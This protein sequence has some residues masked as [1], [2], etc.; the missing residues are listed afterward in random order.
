MKQINTVAMIGRGAIGV[1]YG[2]LFKDKLDDNM[3]YIVDK[4][5]KEK[6]IKNG[7]IVNGKAV[8]FP[9][10]TT[11]DEFQPVDLVFISTK[12]AGLQDAIELM[13]DFVKEDTI[14]VSCLNGIR[15]EDILREAYPNNPVVRTIV[16]GMD[17]TYLHDEVVFTVLGELLFGQELEEEKEAVSL[18]RDF[19]TRMNI[20]FRECENIVFDQWNKLMFN[21]G[22][23]QTCAAYYSTYG[24]CKHEGP[25]RD[26]FIQAMQE[27]KRVANA[28][29]IALSDENIEGWK[30]VL[31]NLGNEG[32]PSMRQDILSHRKTEKA[33][34]S[35]TILPLAKK[36]NMECK[37][38]QELYDRITVIE[39]EM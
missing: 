33:L 16:Q 31:N 34:F 22:I 15:S 26:C 5:R 2:V 36:K 8:E 28:Y 39:N 20:P 3:V 23:N 7:L 19:Y 1:L 35:G 21:C 12:Y 9:Y 27:V 25:L 32:M 11:V 29:G 13:K 24:G 18:L 14:I 38:L 17:S 37:T 4:K 30:R 6:Y 10:V